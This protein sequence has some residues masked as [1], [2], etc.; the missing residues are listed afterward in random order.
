MSACVA[1]GV[2]VSPS[3][4]LSAHAQQPLLPQATQNARLPTTNPTRASSED[5]LHGIGA[6]RNFP[7]SIFAG[8]ERM[9]PQPANNTHVAER[10]PLTAL[11]PFLLTPTNTHPQLR[12]PQLRKIALHC[13]SAVQ[14]LCSLGQAH[15]AAWH[16]RIL[17][18]AAPARMLS[19]PWAATEKASMA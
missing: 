2:A 11:R 15:D 12:P 8:A 13:S 9:L 16:L 17:S 4:L 19:R 10:S 14:R 7:K 6:A 3:N 5:A 1:R 18:G